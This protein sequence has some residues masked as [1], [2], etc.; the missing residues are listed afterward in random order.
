MSNFVNVNKTKKTKE[1]ESGTH[2]QT[3]NPKQKHYL[4]ECKKHSNY[5]HFSMFFNEV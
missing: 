4:A 2:A 1:N 5:F 3:Q